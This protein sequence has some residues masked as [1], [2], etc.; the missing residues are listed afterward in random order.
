[1]GNDD[2]IK[3]KTTQPL[4]DQSDTETGSKELLVV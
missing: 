3:K 4:C 1:M 2:G